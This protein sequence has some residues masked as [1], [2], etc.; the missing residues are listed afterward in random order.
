MFDTLETEE[1]FAKRMVPKKKKDKY[2]DWKPAEDLFGVED[3]LPVIKDK[4][5]KFDDDI[6]NVNEY[7]LNSKTELGM[8]RMNVERTTKSGYI[9]SEKEIKGELT[10]KYKA[11]KQVVKNE[12]REAVAQAKEKKFSRDL[13]KK[14]KYEIDFAKIAAQNEKTAQILKDIAEEQAKRK[15]A[16]MLAKTISSKQAHKQETELLRAAIAKKKAAKKIA[17]HARR[18]ARKVLSPES[19]ENLMLDYSDIGQ[20]FK[21]LGDIVRKSDLEEKEIDLREAQALYVVVKRPDPILPP[22]PEHRS[23]LVE[24]ETFLKGRMHLFSD[25]TLILTCVWA[26]PQVAEIWDMDLDEISLYSQILQERL[27]WID[28]FKVAVNM[29][30]ILRTE[31]KDDMYP[32]ISATFHRK[33]S[34]TVFVFTDCSGEEDKVYVYNEGQNYYGSDSLISFLIDFEMCTSAEREMFHAIYLLSGREIAMNFLCIR[35]HE[36]T[37]KMLFPENDDGEEKKLESEKVEV[38]VPDCGSNESDHKA[39]VDSGLAT[40]TEEEL[41]KEAQAFEAEA[42]RRESSEELPDEVKEEQKR[43]QTLFEHFMNM[44]DQAAEHIGAPPAEAPFAINGMIHSI[45]N[46]FK[47]LSKDF[48]DVQNMLSLLFIWYKTDN[49]WIRSTATRMWLQLNGCDEVTILGNFLLFMMDTHEGLFGDSFF[50][51]V[52]TNPEKA[53]LS[54]E[55]DDRKFLNPETLSEDVEYFANNLDMV[56]SSKAAQG[57]RSL[58]TYA[59]VYKCFDKHQAQQI[60]D[61][62]GKPDKIPIYDL[63][64]IVLQNVAQV[65]KVG[66]LISKGIPLHLALTARDP[67][68]VAQAKVQ[69]LIRR[70]HTCYQ[71]IP[72]DGHIF[73]GDYLRDLAENTKVLEIKLAKM[74]PLA[75]EYVAINTLFSEAT[76]II[77]HKVQELMCGVRSPPFGVILWGEPGIGKSKMLYLLVAFF[78]EVIGVPFSASY[79]YPRT[80]TSQYWDKYVPW[81]QFVIHYSELGGE[82][83]DLAA[84]NGDPMTEECCSLIDGVKWPLDMSRVEDK[85]AYFA[86]PKLVIADSNNPGLNLEKTKVNP[87]AVKRRFHNIYLKVKEEYRKPGSCEISRQGESNTRLLLDKYAIQYKITRCIN[88]TEVVEENLM[89]CGP[90]DD[91]FKLKRIFQAQC[92]AHMQFNDELNQKYEYELQNPQLYDTIVERKE[93]PSTGQIPQEFD[94]VLVH[95]ER[96][97][98]PKKLEPECY[99]L[100]IRFNL[101]P[102]LMAFLS[103]MLKLY[104][105][106][107][108]TCFLTI[109]EPFGLQERGNDSLIL[110]T[111]P[112]LIWTFGIFLIWIKIWFDMSFFYF[113]LVAPFFISFM[114]IF[115]I[116]YTALVK[117][118]R[119]QIYHFANREARVL[120]EQAV[121]EVGDYV[122]NRIGWM[123]RAMENHYTKVMAALAFLGTTYAAS[124]LY[125]IYSKAEKPL[126]M[127]E[128]ATEFRVSSPVDNEIK[129]REEINWHC[130]KSYKRISGKIDEVWNNQKLF[131]KPAHVG[132][133]TG[134]YTSICS[135]VRRV[136]IRRKVKGVMMESSQYLLGLYDDYAIINTHSV[137]S[138]GEIL[139]KVSRT[140]YLKDKDDVFFESILTPS[141]IVSLYSDISIVRLSATTFSDIRVHLNAEDEFPKHSHG[142]VAG[143]EVK[144]SYIQNPNEKLFLMDKIRGEVPLYNCYDYDL[145]G[146]T[147]GM[148]GLPLIVNKS[149]GFIVAAIHAAGDKESAYCGAVC[150]NLK[151]VKEAAKKLSSEGELI[152]VLGLDKRLEPEACMELEEPSDKSMVYFEKLHGMDYFGKLPGHILANNVSKLKNSF[153]MKQLENVP[154]TYEQFYNCYDWTPTAEFTKPLLMKKKIHGEYVNPWNIN[155]RMMSRS[156]KGL[157]RRKLLQIVDYFEKTWCSEL[158]KR[159]V[160]DL[161][162]LDMET[163]INGVF[164][165]EYCRRISANTAAGFP[166]GGKKDRHIPIVEE[167]NGVTRELTPEL[168]QQYLDMIK[169]YENNCR[170]G[171]YYTGSLKDEPRK[172]DK[173]VKGDT[174]MFYVTPLLYLIACKQFLSPFYTLMNQHRDLF[175]VAI[176]LNFP[177]AAKSVHDEMIAF[178]MFFMEGDYRKYDINVPYDIRWGV[179]TLIYRILKRFGYTDEACKIVIGLLSDNMFLMLIVLKD[180]FQVVGVQP[181]GK[182]Y[183]TEDNCLVGLFLL[184]YAYLSLHPDGKIDSFFDNI[185][186]NLT[187]DD[188]IAAVKE[189]ILVWF[190]NSTYQTFCKEVYGL[191]FTASDKSDQI[192]PFLKVEELTYLKRSFR[193]HPDMK[194]IVAQLDMNSIFKTLQWNMP[195]EVATP[196]DQWLSI[197]RSVSYE[198]FWHSSREQ[199]SKMTN[200]LVERYCLEFGDKFLCDAREAIPSFDKLKN[201]YYEVHSPE[202]MYIFDSDV[203]GEGR[204]PVMASDDEVKRLGPESD[205]ITVENLRIDGCFGRCPSLIE[206][207]ANS[208]SSFIIDQILA[209]ETEAKQ[210]DAELRQKGNQVYSMNYNDVIRTPQYAGNVSYKEAADAINVKESRLRELE[211]SISVLKRAKSK[212]SARKMMLPESEELGNMTEGAI[213]MSHVDTK[214]N[215]TD[216]GGESANKSVVREMPEFVFDA[217]DK[218]SIKKFFRRPVEIGAVALTPLTDFTLYYDIWD[219]WFK[220]ASV[221]A[222]LKNFAFF[223][224]NLCVRI[225]VSGTPFHSGK[226]Q[227]SYIPLG[228]YNDVAARYRAGTALPRGAMLSYYSQIPGTKVID[229]KD[230]EPLDIKFPYISPQPII[231]LFNNSSTALADT[232]S[233]DSVRDLGTLNVVT[234]NQIETSS[235]ETTTPTLYIYAWMED[236]EIGEPTGTVMVLDTESDERIV[237]PVENFATRSGEVS[238]ALEAVPVIG[239]YAKASSIALGALSKLASLFGWST[240]TINTSPHRMKN[241]PFQNAAMVI[242]YDTGKRIV[243]DPKQEISVDPRITGSSEDEMSYSYLVNRETLISQF[244]WDEKDE[245]MIMKKFI[246]VNPAFNLF[247]YKNGTTNIAYCQLSPMGYLSMMHS[248]WRGDIIFRLEFVTTKFARGKFAIAFEPNI[249]QLGLITASIELNK[250]YMVIVDLQETQEI[251]ICVNWAFARAWAKCYD[252]DTLWRAQDALSNGPTNFFE[253]C[254][255]FIFMFPVTQLQVT[256]GTDVHIN[257]YARSE[258][259]K[260]NQLSTRRLPVVKLFPE[261]ET[262]YL[263]PE[264]ETTRAVTCFELNQSICSDKHLCELHYGER[265]TSLRS[266]FKRFCTTVIYQGANATA[267]TQQVWKLHPPI[268]PAINPTVA[269]DITDINFRNFLSYWRYAFIA[270]RGGIRKRFRTTGMPLGPQD[271]VQ[272]SVQTPYF[273][274][275][276][277]ADSLT[278]TYNFAS[279]VG[280]VQFIPH[281]N[282]G[283]EYEI[284]FYNINQFLIS[285]TNTNYASFEGAILSNWYAQ[286]YGIRVDFNFTGQTYGTEDTAT[287]E[288]FSLSGFIAVPPQAWSQ[289]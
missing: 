275:S 69:A 220:V 101:V 235:V 186:P 37:I 217:N 48:Q 66:E 197:I 97:K 168:R 91:V 100:R 39:D 27:L 113:C 83:P 161:K 178:S 144:V 150:F 289:T 137:F 42:K 288:D 6:E 174:R 76:R 35:A 28:T 173:V 253:F 31:S 241:E 247:P 262:R 62:F 131:V 68:S 249:A 19:E 115:C 77:N 106:V 117:E 85:G 167:I 206:W 236:F 116:N 182:A 135:N 277:S 271:S 183:T 219:L 192:K 242:G 175:K 110:V 191:D 10:A 251:E 109:V 208:T 189:E 145:P 198:L 282:G 136:I 260:F 177:L 162:P 172:L 212:Q 20:V 279:Q 99:D 103:K 3:E 147:V 118:L 237:G 205:V 143:K 281:T 49:W 45:I 60:Y 179:S 23:I 255:G 78:C 12:K 140:G 165:D 9:K 41:Y 257:V 233:L 269:A 124:Q 123:P 38:D 238:A 17:K 30:R 34:K 111:V 93:H 88:N 200:F 234:L 73:I 46:L 272:V 18:D 133:P 180:L 105:T 153:F 94:Y 36:K 40:P 170:H 181:S 112:R 227:I 226:L 267:G 287:G 29:P 4:K 84:R 108:W 203:V 55:S 261:S 127:Q 2:S 75:P 259:M 230:N 283:V 125:A 104:L 225:V 188:I 176:G 265:P 43:Q 246:P 274:E 202:K 240:P 187:G 268:M 157:N 244:I 5:Y 22:N 232:T 114:L 156:I 92:R 254:N 190:N 64:K 74:N 126:K 95:G 193:D 155:M 264:S 21:Y 252:Y 248:V 65:I 142:I 26:R 90:D 52:K 89:D 218:S 44:F 158:R 67:T 166:L 7:N 82:K 138:E 86:I 57:F 81:V 16:E 63:M 284:P 280:N 216:I 276:D 11:H 229:I 222:K 51:R 80:K 15:E 96:V 71:T 263:L 211:K 70:E 278:T 159:E 1:K 215:V 245:P 134:L 196:E 209:Y 286:N 72:L 185:L 224:G 231:R 148:C 130:G 58:L 120:Y 273:D 210:L 87:A 184:A 151:D 132:D 14:R 98:I 25:R 256:S 171:I 32:G 195:S 204:Q 160:P 47:Q 56:M 221:R 164:Y 250:Q 24:A 61:W 199:Y 129:D 121:N 59:A 213:D 149:G 107:L 169:S 194:L 102:R 258:N 13:D 270:W 239:I 79:I 154:D 285:G 141:D 228:K 223:R 53:V 146:H 207:P 128:E 33:D 201:M 214:E 122:N 163:A 54:T 266:V 139:L 119:V 8:S 243:L 152:P 50:K